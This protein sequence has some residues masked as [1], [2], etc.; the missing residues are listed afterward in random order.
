MRK[1]QSVLHIEFNVVNYFAVSAQK[2]DDTITL[3]VASHRT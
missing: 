1:K 3:S 2:V